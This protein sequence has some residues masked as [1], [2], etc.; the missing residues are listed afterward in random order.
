MNGEIELAYSQN[1]V[2]VTMSALV[3]SLIAQLANSGV[4]TQAQATEI[5]HAALTKSS[6]TSPELAAEVREVLRDMFPNINLPS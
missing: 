1:A 4:L 3:S 6:R 5:I 2:H